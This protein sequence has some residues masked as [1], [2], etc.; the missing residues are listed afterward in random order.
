MI[1]EDWEIKCDRKSEEY[2]LMLYLKNMFERVLT[3]EENKNIESHLSK[4]EVINV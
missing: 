4:M 3:T 2:D 1:P